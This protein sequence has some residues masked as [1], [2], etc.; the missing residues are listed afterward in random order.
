MRKLP[1]S[2]VHRQGHDGPIELSEKLKEISPV[3]ASKILFGSVGLGS[4]RHAD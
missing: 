4:Q 2:H 1:F 3:P